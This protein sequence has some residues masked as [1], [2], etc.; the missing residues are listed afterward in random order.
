MFLLKTLEDLA[1]FGSDIFTQNSEE[2]VRQ[3]FT[4]TLKFVM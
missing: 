2:M 4:A 1:R 3:G